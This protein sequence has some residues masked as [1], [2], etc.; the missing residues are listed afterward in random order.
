MEQL[1]TVLT[2]KGLHDRVIELC[3]DYWNDSRLASK[4]TH[5]FIKKGD[6]NGAVEFWKGI[7]ATFPRHRTAR[8]EL[9]RSFNANGDTDAIVSFWKEKFL[10]PNTGRGLEYSGNSTDSGNWSTLIII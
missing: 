3:K 4:L 1:G 9:L 10:N 2:E 6:A 7:F 8:E 5:A